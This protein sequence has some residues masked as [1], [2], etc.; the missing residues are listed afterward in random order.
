[1]K[2][3]T[4]TFIASLLI[5]FAS[6]QQKEPFLVFD[7]ESFD[8]GKIQEEGGQATHKYIFTNTG[9]LPLVIKEVKPS[10]GCTTPDWTREPIMPGNKGFVAAI[11]N[12]AGRP[13][14]FTKTVTVTSNAT[15]NPVTLK[16]TGTVTPK[17]K[18]PEDTYP[19]ILDS[20]RLTSNFVYFDSIYLGEVKT[21]KIDIWNIRKSAS[22]ISL[23]NV[24]K[25]IKITIKP[26]ATLKPDEKG[27][28]EIIYYTKDKNDW[29]YVFD[30][31]QF[32]VNE[33]PNANNRI[34]V[35][36]DIKED[37]AK[38]TEK[39]IANAPVIS[40][41]ENS[42]DFGTVKKGDAVKHDFE[43]TNTGKSE[44]IIRKISASCGCTLAELQS[45]V[46]KPGETTKVIAT[47]NTASK[48]KGDVATTIS[49]VTNDPKNSKV[50]LF[51]R[52]IVTTDEKAQPDTK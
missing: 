42:Y 49:L 51:F 3:I 20:V 28:I 1:M 18:R 9:S 11:Y 32:V 30:N 21:K 43:I 48:A 40:V 34:T 36:A 29:G 35:S 16:F 38:L 41:K 25:H 10:C 52:G 15:N 19:I 23:P 50:I 46:I 12:P 8:F 14:P 2:R 7:S 47:L 4:L 24:P 37:F 44:L 6:A 22:V 39:Q 17:A 27:F 13:G 31:I 26:S 33:K 45:K 5:L